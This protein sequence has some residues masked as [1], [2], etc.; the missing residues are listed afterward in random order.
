MSTD[1]EYDAESELHFALCVA[2][3]KRGA[4][5]T[6]RAVP[7]S[8]KCR[9]HNMTHEE[10]VE[11]GSRGG[12]KRAA[13]LREQADPPRQEYASSVTLEEILE[14][15][16]P[17]LLATFDATGEADWNA[18]LQ[19]AGVLVVSFPRHLRDTP[20]KVRELL[21]ASLPETVRPPT[22][23]RLHADAIFKEMRH[24]WD[25]LS[26]RHHPITGLY[27]PEYPSHM[28]APWEHA[29]EVQA[30][31]PDVR[32]VPTLTIAGQTYV[33]RE[34]AIPMLVESD[35]ADAS[36]SYEAYA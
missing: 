20:E 13:M 29:A 11:A 8:D 23:E 10:F 2:T 5:C 32:D 3:T 21:D 7:G 36:A 26:I 17:A 34:G 15:C 19:A 24:S 14:V 18:R 27:V 33:Q 16:G 28:I 4:P 9:I 22:R 25:E 12:K 1:E 6:H 35:D 31:R 30:A